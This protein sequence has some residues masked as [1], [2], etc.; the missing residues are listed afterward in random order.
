MKI[1]KYF[2]V[3]F[4]ATS[5]CAQEVVSV[6]DP[7]MPH[8]YTFVHADQSLERVSQRIAE[9]DTVIDEITLEELNDRESLTLL[10]YQV[11]RL[12]EKLASIRNSFSSDKTL[13]FLNL[14]EKTTLM[15]D[16]DLARIKLK[17]FE[18]RQTT[19]ISRKALAFSS[20]EPV[21]MCL[22]KLLYYPESFDQSCTVLVN[23]GS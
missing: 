20:N 19:I 14:E 1:Y 6:K 9:L 22:H 4:M 21:S 16:E 7:D 3:F 5:V 17:P 10:L 15:T 13:S 23:D 12:Q 8:S 2:A 11:S 18:K